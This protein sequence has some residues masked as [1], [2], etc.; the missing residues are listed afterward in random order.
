VASSFDL[1][2]SKSKF[3]FIFSERGP[4]SGSNVNIQSAL[5]VLKTGGML[6][7]ETIGDL[8]SQEINEFFH[9]GQ[10]YIKYKHMNRVD[11]VKVL[12]ERNEI[13]IRI[14]NNLMSYIIF[15]DIYE[16]LS[17]QCPVWSYT[18]IDFPSLDKVKEFYFYNKNKNQ[19][20]KIIIT[21]HRIWIGGIKQHNPPEYWVFKHFKK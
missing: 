11:E 21:R 17:Y 3:D 7:E 10:Q 19:K 4:I 6:F 9:R 18:G 5:N 16:W 2:F 12:F 14:I 13:D 8:D 1:P 15:P 20:G